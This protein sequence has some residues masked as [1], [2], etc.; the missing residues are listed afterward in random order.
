M[1][2]D[3]LNPELFTLEHYDSSMQWHLEDDLH[4]ASR[5]GFCDA[6]RLL[7]R[8]RSGEFALMIEWPN[9]EKCWGHTSARQLS[10][11][12]KRLARRA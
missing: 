1:N 10:I 9:G 12:R 8:P 3:E 11:I 4:F 2:L 7:V 5:F 6:S